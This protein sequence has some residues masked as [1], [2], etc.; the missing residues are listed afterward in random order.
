MSGRDIPACKHAVDEHAQL[1][2]VECTHGKIGAA[3]IGD[4]IHILIATAA[5]IVAKYR[6]IFADCL[7]L[8][9]YAVVV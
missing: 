1:G 5:K 7:A 8:E 6:N 2:I 4:D 9:L 3:A